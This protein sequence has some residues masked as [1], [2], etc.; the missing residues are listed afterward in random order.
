M[1]VVQFF[2]ELGYKIKIDGLLSTAFNRPIIDIFDFDYQVHK[3]FD[4]DNNHSLEYLLTK[5]Y[6]IEVLDKIKYFSGAKEY[7]G[8][9]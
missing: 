8:K 6:D 7:G 2:L 1:E 5:Y 9:K 3:K 4:P